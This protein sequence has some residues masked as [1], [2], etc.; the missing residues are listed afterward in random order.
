MSE[1]SVNRNRPD[2]SLV[3]A[4]A[5]I[6]GSLGIER[7]I[8]EPE[9]FLRAGGVAWWSEAPVTA[10]L[11]LVNEDERRRAEYQRHLEGLRRSGAK[12][13]ARHV[14]EWDR[15]IEGRVVVLP[16]F[17]FRSAVTVSTEM[18]VAADGDAACAYTLLRLC[19]PPYIDRLFRCQLEGCANFYAYTGGREGPPPRY[20]CPEH[21][22]KAARAA[23]VKRMQAFRK[24]HRRAS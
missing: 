12:Y 5:N 6:W 7:A 9:E 22:L 21:K 15:A 23:G 8:P 10:F 14:R 3:S 13:A 4:I 11:Q 19:A 1:L 24:A 16:T 20:C 17:S 2:V 18:V